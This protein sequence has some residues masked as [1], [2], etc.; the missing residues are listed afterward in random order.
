MSSSSEN[1]GNVFDVAIVGLGPVGATAANL[2]GKHGY[3][4]VVI[5]REPEIYDKPRAISFDQEAMRVF[6]SIGLTEEILTCTTRYRPALYLGAEGQVI[7]RIDPSPEPFP[8][9]WLPNYLFNQPGLEKALRHG[10]RRFE[11]IDVRLEH[12]VRS[13]AQKRDYV[14]LT[15]QDLQRGTEY[16]LSAHYVWACDGAGSPVRHLMDLPL[17][18][19]DFDEEWIVIDVKVN[20]PTILP[21]TNIQYCEPTRPSTYVV[22]PGNH[23][24]WELMLNPGESPEEVAKEERILDLLRRWGEPSNFDI[25][26]AAVYRFHA[27]VA[28]TWS[29]GRVYLLGDAAHQT[30][31]F[32]GQGM[33][34]GIRDAANLIWKLNQVERFKA[35]ATLFAHYERERKPHVK[36]L[37]EFT[38]LL[39]KTICERDPAK[40]RA[41][42]AR[43]EE[44]LRSGRMV[45]VRQNLIPNLTEG[46]L[47]LANGVPVGP[48]GRLFP[49]PAV[50]D[51]AGTEALLDDIIGAGFLLVVQ[52]PDMLDGL[53]GEDRDWFERS[54]GQIVV[55]TDTPSGAEGQITAMNTVLSSVFDAWECSALLVR[56]DKYIFGAAAD[57]HAAGALL[58]RLRP[59]IS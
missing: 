41:R 49:Q 36:A 46:V 51:C 34:Q 57:A 8:L 18:D 58:N 3:K 4:T 43:L 10:L 1:H 16:D 39:G 31:P 14:R 35:P 15:V 55:V 47:D 9:H 27:L 56:P 26:R 19:L 45:T 13:M 48:A 20:D 59:F 38:K 54:G 24:R 33:C 53:S 12:E 42:D 37:T 44:D 50:I 17:E 52:R 5:E 21:E 23:R 40:A 22:G 6:Q 28:I 7:R 32:M 30:P 2:L 29:K 25:W 11:S